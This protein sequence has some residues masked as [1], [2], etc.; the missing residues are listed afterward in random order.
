M[1]LIPQPRYTIKV[2]VNDGRITP[3]SPLTIKNQIRQIPSNTIAS[4]EDIL[5]VAT[6]E[7]VDGS[8]IVY[9]ST[10]D[11]YEVKK[12]PTLIDLGTF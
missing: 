5:D 3:N 10:T 8:T 12:L 7:V 1:S 2:S 4:I 6:V 9:N 11:K